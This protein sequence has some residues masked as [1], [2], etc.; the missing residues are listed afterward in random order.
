MMQ[1]PIKK[2]AYCK[3]E[4][5]IEDIIKSPQIKPIGMAFNDIN[6]RAAFYFFQHDVPE[7]GTSFLINV[8]E[9]AEYVNSPPDLEKLSMSD[10][11]EE[12]CVSID[13]FNSCQQACHYAAYRAFLLK[14]IEDKGRGILDYQVSRKSSKTTG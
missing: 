7:C 8:E 9:F 2:C 12:H 6:T 13:D 1:K 5:T 3:A 14:M 11:C 4:L 10:C